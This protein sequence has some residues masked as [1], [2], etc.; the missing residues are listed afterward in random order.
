MRK[1][2]LPL[3]SRDVSIFNTLKSDEKEACIQG[4]GIM[5]SLRYE[6]RGR[7]CLLFSIQ[8]KGDEGDTEE[9]DA[10]SI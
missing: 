5:P 7:I 2:C 10:E 6:A 9:T 8:G 1:I 3:R 4:A